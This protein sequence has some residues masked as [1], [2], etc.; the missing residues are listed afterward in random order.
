MRPTVDVNAFKYLLFGGFCHMALRW[1]ILEQE[2]KFD[3]M[4]ELNEMVSL[5]TRSVSNE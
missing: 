1:L 4:N 2:G 3:K 5:M